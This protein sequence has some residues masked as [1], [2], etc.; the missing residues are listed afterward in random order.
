M[1]PPPGWDTLTP[2]EIT[3]IQYDHHFKLLI[4]KI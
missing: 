3:R 1:I 2:Q 4:P